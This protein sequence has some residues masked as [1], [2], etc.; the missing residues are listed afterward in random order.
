MDLNQPLSHA[1]HPTAIFLY[2][3]MG[4]STLHPSLDQR[5]REEVEHKKNDTVGWSKGRSWGILVGHQHFNEPCPSL[6]VN[7]EPELHFPKHSTPPHRAH[8]TE[9]LPCPSCVE[10]TH[11]FRKRKQLKKN[12][13]RLK[14]QIELFSRLIFNVAIGWFSVGG[15]HWDFFGTD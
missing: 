14:L 5:N 3:Q 11:V 9:K 4:T 15:N 6:Q 12:Q 7:K 13:N 8:N 1:C 2:S 10:E